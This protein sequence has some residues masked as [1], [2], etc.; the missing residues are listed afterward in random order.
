VPVTVLPNPEA[1]VTAEATM[2][3]G[4]IEVHCPS[5]HVVRMPARDAATLRY[6]FAA[7]AP[8]LAPGEE[9]SPC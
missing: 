7:L 3:A 8:P 1:A 2:P 5:G 9:M 4:T 6:L